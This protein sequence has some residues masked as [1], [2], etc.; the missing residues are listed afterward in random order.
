MVE[1]GKAGMLIPAEGACRTSRGIAFHP[2]ELLTMLRYK[3]I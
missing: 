2:L 3:R 1:E